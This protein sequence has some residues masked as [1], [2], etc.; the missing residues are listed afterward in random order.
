MVTPV[1]QRKVVGST[2]YA[3]AINVMS[4]FEC[5]RLYG[6]Q[7]KVNRVEGVVVNVDQ[8]ITKQKRKK[9]YVISDYKNIDRSFKRVRLHIKSVVLGPVLVLDTVNLPATAPL[10][11]D[12]TTT[13]LPYNPS[14]SVTV[15]QYTPVDSTHINPAPVPTNTTNNFDPA[16]ISKTTSIP[17]NRPNI[18][19]PATDPTI[20]T[21]VTSNPPTTVVVNLIQPPPH[22]SMPILRLK[23]ILYLIRIDLMILLPL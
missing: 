21:T 20:N 4:E 9:F 6:S 5:N 19:A 3:K 17:V 16:L 22:A 23:M 18:V 12:T 1:D 10:L 8:Q 7:N 2:V 11:T 15:N 13:I 14:T